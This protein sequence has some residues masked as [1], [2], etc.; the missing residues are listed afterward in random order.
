VVLLHVG[1]DCV[2]WRLV[3]GWRGS[4]SEW[5][6]PHCDHY[7][8]WRCWSG[9]YVGVKRGCCNQTK[10]TFNICI[11]FYFYNLIVLIWNSVLELGLSCTFPLYF[12]DSLCN[13]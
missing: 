5:Q 2:V 11:G 4:S 7:P 12:T 13:F 1:S 9:E 8:H 3:Q 6:G 10:Y